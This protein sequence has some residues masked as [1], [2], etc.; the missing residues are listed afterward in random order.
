MSR[1]FGDM[2]GFADRVQMS[3]LTHRVKRSQI[4]DSNIAN[5][6]TPGFRALSYDFEEQLQGISDPENKKQLLVSNPEHFRSAGVGANGQIEPDLYITP[7]ES[8][9]NDGNTVEIDHEMA[10]LAQNQILYRATIE[11]IN[12]KIGTLRYAIQ[13]GR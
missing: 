4:I 1:I 8:V 3:S 13:G 10:E 6:E 11:S 9:G 2:F 5:A 7:T 12:K